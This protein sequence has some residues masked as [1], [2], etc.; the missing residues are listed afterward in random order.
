[1][2]VFQ[3]C[4]HSGSGKT[5]L[6]RSIIPVMKRTGIR[7]GSVKSIHRDDFHIDT[8]GKDTAVQGEAGADP[9]VARGPD[10]TDFLYSRPMDLQEIVSMIASDWIVVEGFADFPLPRIVCGKTAADI[11]AFLDE[12]TFAVAGPVCETLE[13]FHDLPVFNMNKPDQVEMLVRLISETVFPMLPYTDSGECGE[14][15]MDCADLAAAII[16]GKRE[17]V[18][19][20]YA[21]SEMSLKIG[22]RPI[23]MNAFVRSVLRKTV[24]AVV[25]EL[26]GYREGDAIEITIS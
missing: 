2:F 21:G 10:E 4:G 15:G 23:H 6:I 11:N 14:C 13:T 26:K 9:V 5:T 16:K 1:M 7:L 3:I 8:P 25:S 17:Y 20:V 12:R 24:Q 18:D 19:C 22:D